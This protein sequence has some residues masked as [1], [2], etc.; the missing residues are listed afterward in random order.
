MTKQTTETFFLP[1]EIDRVEW[2]TP[3]LIYNLYRSLLIRNDHQPVFVPIRSMQYL[4][5]LDS[6]EINF[7][8]SQSYAVSGKTGG[9][10]ILLA[11][12][13]STADSRDSLDKPVR[14]EVVFYKQGMDDIQRRLIGEF[15][16]A[17]EI[18]DQ[19]YRD[20]LPSTGSVDIVSI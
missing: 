14:C 15:K 20:S 7:V 8:D 19:R 9:R 4:A 10:M 6:H 12:C 11:W 17:L 5:I 3:A 2:T 13:F 1:K 18:L 16:Q